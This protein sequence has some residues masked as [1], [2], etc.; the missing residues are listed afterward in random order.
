MLFKK[1]TKL[2]DELIECSICKGIG[3][4]IDEPCWRC[5][6]TGKIKRGNM[7]NKKEVFF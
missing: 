2:E 5:N 7:S 3:V 6:G 1:K 4:F